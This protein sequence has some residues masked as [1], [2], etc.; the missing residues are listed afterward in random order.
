[1]PKL[2][3]REFS[4]EVP[5]RSDTQ[6]EPN[7][8]TIAENVRLYAGELQ[9][10]RGPTLDFEPITVDIRTI[11]QFR[12]PSTSEDIWLT[13]DSVVDVQPS[14]LADDTDFRLYYTG[15][16]APKK[17]NYAM[18]GDDT[19]GG[20]FPGEYLNLGVPAPTAAPT[21]AATTG[22]SATADS[23]YYVYTFISTFGNLEEESAPSPVSDLVSI[24][25]SQSVDLSDIEDTPVGDYN[26]T[27]VRIYRTVPG[28]QTIGS[29]VF[30]KEIAIG[31]A[32][33]NDDL[34]PDELGEPLATVTWAEPPSNLQGLTSMANGMMAGFVGNSVYFCEPY[35]HHAW[36]AQYIQ[37]ISDQIVGLGAYGNTLVVMT[38]GQPVAMIGVS[39]DAMV[40]EK[41]AMP[42][43]CVSA[44]SIAVDQ[45]GVLYASPNGLVSIG[46]GGRGVITN[47][48]FRR[49][50]WQ[51][52]APET[53]V[54][55]IYDG[56]Y[57]A[58]FE[59]VRQGNKTMVVSRDDIP[60]LSFLTIRA[61]AFFSSVEEGELY[62]L[63]TENDKIYQVDSDR[64]NPYT[65]EWT[66]KRFH[67][68][69]GVTWSVVK[70][71]VDTV[72]LVANE[73]YQALLA[74]V[75]AANALITGNVFGAF[76][77]N[78]YNE[79]PVNGSIL[80][81]IPVEA[82]LLSCTLTFLG[83]QDEIESVLTIEDITTRRIPPFRSR[84]LKVKLSGT[85]NVR[86]VEIATDM[87]ALREVS[88]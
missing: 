29:Y 43:P 14:S 84:A 77:A 78:T 87:S 85:L 21:V 22:T 46:Q 69:Q 72:Q 18:A 52:Y 49:K 15:D 23:R 63:D 59:S 19:A 20:E 32:T 6:L 33:T 1:M 25:A 12:N 48:L 42:E 71:D 80:Q 86:G 55:A 56:K 24:T 47:K 8:A 39:P 40:V 45:Y 17:T 58:T 41:I 3:I 88:R 50:E 31:T 81:E 26:I 27:A 13:W 73:D 75:T 53:M 60:A 16:G 38:T 5:R 79:Y 82:A 68:T 37:S 54:G 65:Y 83:E 57:F 7:E 64:L 74:Q 35:F 67:Y 51:E 61:R 9:A 62:Y 11:Y 76:N 70:V 10:F 2:T 66:S 36:P 28:E 4:G 30:V 34:A 44:K